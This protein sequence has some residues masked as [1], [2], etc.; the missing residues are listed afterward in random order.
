MKAYKVFFQHN[1]YS[2]DHKFEGVQDLSRVVVAESV[3]AA[4][5][6]KPPSENWRVSGVKEIGTVDF[7][8]SASAFEAGLLL[9][10]KEEHGEK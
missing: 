6:A 2:V 5:R 4:A 7:D 8:A 3:T 10:Y 1:E 9:K